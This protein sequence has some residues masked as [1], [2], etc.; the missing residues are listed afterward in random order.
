MFEVVGKYTNLEVL[1]SF[2]GRP[3]QMFCV[4]RPLRVVAFE[5]HHG[6]KV[7]QF[8]TIEE[9]VAIKILKISR[10]HLPAFSHCNKLVLMFVLATAFL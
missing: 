5:T 9:T 7:F 3:K 4:L 8:L 1:L 10:T 6:S 2:T